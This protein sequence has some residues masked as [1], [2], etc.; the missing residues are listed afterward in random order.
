MLHAARLR[1]LRRL[2]NSHRHPRMIIAAVA[3]FPGLCARTETA[4]NGTLGACTASAASRPVPIG[5]QSSSHGASRLKFV[6]QRS[7]RSGDLASRAT[8]KKA[9]RQ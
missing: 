1:V 3:T 4:V 5:S 2:G 7:R 6:T 8:V 9:N